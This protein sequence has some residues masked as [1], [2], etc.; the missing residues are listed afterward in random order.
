MG[1]YEPGGKG[2]AITDR[3]AESACA[4]DVGQYNRNGGE[5]HRR[6]AEQ[7]TGQKG[8]QTGNSAHLHPGRGIHQFTLP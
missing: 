3:L 5:S 1:E 4:S 7:K 2:Q 6:K 8:T